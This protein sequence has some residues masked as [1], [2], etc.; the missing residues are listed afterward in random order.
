MHCYEFTRYSTDNP[1]N[2]E[3]L[4]QEV[5]LNLK[6]IIGRF[7]LNSAIYNMLG[8][9]WHNDT[10]NTIVSQHLFQ[11]NKTLGQHFVKKK[12]SANISEDYE[13]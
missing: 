7:K 8:C 3:F 5:H 12:K 1:G 13:Q 11:K 6:R 9:S 4:Q 10:D 2:N